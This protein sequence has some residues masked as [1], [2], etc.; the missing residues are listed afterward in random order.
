MNWLCQE[1]EISSQIVK[2]TMEDVVSIKPQESYAILFQVPA[3]MK[4][5]KISYNIVYTMENDGAEFK[6]I[7][8]MRF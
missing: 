1:E 8:Y 5:L 2:S 6:M 3:N 7:K 4:D